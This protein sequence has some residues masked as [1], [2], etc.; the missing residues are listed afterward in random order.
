MSRLS[1][2]TRLFTVA[3]LLLALPAFA[4]C[5]SDSNSEDGGGDNDAVTVDLSDA[6]TASYTAVGGTKQVT[7]TGADAGVELEIVNSDDEVVATGTTDDA[8]QLLVRSLDPGDGYVVVQETDDGVAASEPTDVG[9]LDDAPDE[10]FYTD[11]TLDTGDDGTGGYG[12]LETR[13]GTLLAY[14]LTLPGPADEGPY[15]TVVEYSG[16][17]PANPDSPQ[18]STLIAGLLGYATV[19]INMR[20][21]GCSGGSFFFQEP[22]QVTDGYDAVEVVAAQPWVLDNEV[23]LVGLSYPGLTQLWTAQTNPP[24]LEAIAP[25]SVIDDTYRSTLYPGGIF[26]TG[27]AEDWATERQEESEPGGQ[28]WAQKRIDDGDEVCIENQEL[29]SQNPDLLELVSENDFYDNAELGDPLAPI[30]FVDEI[31]VPVFIAGAWQDEQTGG[32][33]PAMLPE[34]TGTDQLQATFVNG[35]HPDPLGPEI[36][37][38]WVEFLSFYVKKE[39]PSIDPLVQ[40]VGPSALGEEIWGTADFEI[41]DTRFSEYDDYDEALAA[42]EAEQPVRVVFESGAGGTTPGAPVATFDLTF[43]DWPIPE[44]EATTWYLGA[45]GTLSDAEG[46]DD[47]AADV[48]TNDPTG[49]D[50]TTLDV[51]SQSDA[52]VTEPPYTWV[53]PDEGEGLNYVTDPFDETTIMAGHGSADLWISSTAEDVDLEVQV[54]EVRPDGKEVYVTAGWLRASHRALDEEASTELRP[55]HT[56]ESADAEPV[57]DDE[58]VEARVE[59]FPFAHVFREGSQLRITIDAPGGSRPLWQFDTVEEAE[60]VEVGRSAAAPSAVVLPVIPGVGSEA[61][62]EYPACGA[63]RGQPCRDY[64]AFANSPAE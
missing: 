63:L 50:D 15:P 24:S 38:R 5:T 16:Y 44:T 37:S 60:P 3:T 43:D 17:D 58:F 12:Y 8:G 41:Q 27:F 53:Q 32:H 33:W 51:E 9:G 18:P 19:G 39:I 54:S 56:H 36:F 20:G 13:D 22:A 48:Y 1:L 6:T 23:G 34:F 42:F 46:P 29:R 30:T 55:V 64:A 4:G 52:W 21:T 47:A 61:P 57:P 11:Q 28:E 2:R 49:K 7:V 35:T 40:A 45:D 59:L 25:L 26:N 62:A 10:S 31:D 14:N